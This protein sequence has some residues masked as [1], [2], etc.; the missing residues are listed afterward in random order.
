[1]A[2]PLRFSGPSY[3]FFAGFFAAFF[4]AF[5]ADFFA[6]LCAMALPCCQ[7]PS[8]APVG[9]TNTPIRAHLADIHVIHGNRGPGFDCG[10][11]RLLHAVDLHIG[12]PRTGAPG[13]GCFCI[14]PPTPPLTSIMV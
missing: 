10:R 4:A 11:D 2:E 6:A 5:F 1:M 7:T 14:P 8:V 13:I 9:S 12:H 3:F